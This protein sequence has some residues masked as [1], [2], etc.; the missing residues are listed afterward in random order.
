MLNA[1][2]QYSE[3]HNLNS[4][5]LH[6]I[7]TEAQISQSKIKLFIKRYHK[8]KWEGPKNSVNIIN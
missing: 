1:F 6:F 5:Y 4:I 2:I 8:G 3:Y 7:S